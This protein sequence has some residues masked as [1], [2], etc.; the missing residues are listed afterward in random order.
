MQHA[1]DSVQP[2][3]GC[4]VRHYR[5]PSVLGEMS[6]SL[7]YP[8]FTGTGRAMHYLRVLQARAEEE[9]QPCGERWSLV[10]ISHGAGGTRFDQ[11]YLAEYLAAQGF[12]VLTV[13]HRDIQDEQ[14]RWRNLLTRP[15][16]LLLAQRALQQE[17][18]AENIDFSKPL[19]IGHSAG[20]YDVLV[21]CGCLPRFDL[22]EEFSTVLKELSTFEL[23][24]CQ[25]ESPLGVVLMAPALSNLF[26]QES[27]LF[28]KIPVLILSAEHDSVHMLGTPT[29]Y[30]AR[31]PEV[32]HHTLSGAGHYA[33]VH[34]SPP[35]LRALNL[36]VSGGDARPRKQLHDEIINHLMA[37]CDRLCLRTPAF[38]QGATTYV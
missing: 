1:V 21:K 23:A 13:D 11:Y 10:V 31:L 6:A 17:V 32:I 3:K 25:L 27:L 26:P 14:Q 28:M 34:E 33:F 35:I 22:E 5:W 19:L 37:F 2:G 38:S 4:G 29:D 15:M 36:V 12:A 9:A 16:R 24:T 8:A 18:L 30:A 20:A 7:W